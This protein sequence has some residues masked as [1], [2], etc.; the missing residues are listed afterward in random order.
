MKILLFA[1]T[2]MGNYVVDAI[3]N[4]EKV[5]ELIVIT[6]SEPNT[7]PYFHCSHLN[8]YCNSLNIP[9]YSIQNFPSMGALI[10][11]VLLYSPD[12][13]A[14]ATFHTILPQKLINCAGFEAINIHPSLLPMY[15][16]PNPTN[17]V[18]VNGEKETG[19]TIHRVTDKI[20]TGD[21][22]LQKS[23]IIDE[24]NDGE[25]RNRLYQVGATMFT[26]IVEQLFSN[27]IQARPMQEAGTFFPGIKTKSGLAILRQ[28][29]FIYE[30]LVRG[31]SPYP[32]ITIAEKDLNGV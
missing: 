12:L 4:D 26:E 17:W 24:E 14:I 19:V 20:D 8:D 30:N 6:R 2:G 1:L 27:K 18:L 22:L 32:G 13:I 15:K 21:I 3:G 16:G 5:N 29:E 11:F 9:C 25:L 31:L 28:G 23:I 7:Y 10:D